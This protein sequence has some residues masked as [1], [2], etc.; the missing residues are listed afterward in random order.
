MNGQKYG[1]WRRALPAAALTVATAT[2][3]HAGV[4]WNEAADGDLAELIDYSAASAGARGASTDIGTLSAEVSTII[5]RS[6][7]TT[8][9]AQT[10]VDGDS[11]LFTVPAGMRASV[12]AFTH[13]LPLGVR[14]FLRVEDGG[15]GPTFILPR[16]YP[17]VVLPGGGQNLLAQFGVSGGLGAGSYI[18]SFENGATATSTMGYGIDIVIEPVPAPG[19]AAAMV[20]AGLAM[21][22]WPRRRRR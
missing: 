4:V 14:E 20:G 8:T 15:G 13:D 5:G 21:A 3:A 22:G 7:R 9:N 16:A 10:T 6:A 1:L 12:L 19:G 17:P 11:L 2:N 18:L